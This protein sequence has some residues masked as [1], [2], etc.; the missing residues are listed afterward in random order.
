METSC[1]YVLNIGLHFE[2]DYVENT[3]VIVCFYVL[4][5][6]LRFERS[7]PLIADRTRCF[8]VLNVGLCFEP[9]IG[10]HGA[11]QPAVSMS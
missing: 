3:F 8:Y 11:N 6:G 2:P 9:C 10:A 4:N 5:I 1:F 7:N